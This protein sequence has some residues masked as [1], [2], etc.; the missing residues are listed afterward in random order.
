MGRNCSSCRQSFE[1][2]VEARGELEAAARAK[3][4][5]GANQDTHQFS[6]DLVRKIS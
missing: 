2:E 3:E 4:L 6:I 1:C 5:S